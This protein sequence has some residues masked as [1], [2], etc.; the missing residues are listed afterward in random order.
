MRKPIEVAVAAI[1]ICL[2]LYAMDVFTLYAPLAAPPT[3]Q[4]RF[5]LLEMNVEYNNMSHEKAAALIKETN[6]DVVVIEELTPT[7][8]CL[9]SSHDIVCSRGNRYVAAKTKVFIAS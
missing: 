2:N 4:I 3:A 5:K 9:M 7:L 8:T 1:G 6:A